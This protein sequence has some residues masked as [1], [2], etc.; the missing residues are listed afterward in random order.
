MKFKTYRELGNEYLKPKEELISLIDD[1]RWE[2]AIEAIQKMEAIFGRNGMIINNFLRLYDDRKTL[3]WKVEADTMD[4]YGYVLK[5]NT[6][7]LSKLQKLE[8]IE[9]DFDSE[10]GIWYSTELDKEI[11]KEDT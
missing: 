1:G 7:Y 3:G 6:S 2:L 4:N 8:E 9:R 5:D 11:Q 10:I